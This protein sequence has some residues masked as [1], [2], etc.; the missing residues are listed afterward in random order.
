MLEALRATIRRCDHGMLVVTGCM[1]RIATC[2]SRF[3]GPGVMVVLQPCSIDRVP[4]EPALWI[5]PINDETDVCI[6]CD[7]L[8][9]GEWDCH[10]LPARL[11][12]TTG[13]NV[14]ILN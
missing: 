10:A 1:L 4:S 6:L 3:H 12:R 14:G 8:Q 5:G 9:R 13:R 11:C 7:W 2:G